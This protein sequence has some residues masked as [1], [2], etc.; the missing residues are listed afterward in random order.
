MIYCAHFMLQSTDAIFAAARGLVDSVSQRESDS[1]PFGASIL[2]VLQL[3]ASSA[4]HHDAQAVLLLDKN[5]NGQVSF[6]KV[7]ELLHWSSKRLL[8]NLCRPKKDDFACRLLSMVLAMLSDLFYLDLQDEVV[9]LTLRDWLLELHGR[10]K[11]HP[12]AF[13]RDTSLLMP[14]LLRIS[15]LL[16]LSKDQVDFHVGELSV[17][18]LS[19]LLLRM[20]CAT[21]DDKEETAVLNML[22]AAAVA[23]AAVQS[24][25]VRLAD[26]L[27]SYRETG[28]N[29]KGWA[30]PTNSP[31][32]SSGIF[33]H[34]ALIEASD[35]KERT[36]RV[37][38][39]LSGWQIGAAPYS[40]RKPLH[41]VSQ[42]VV[43]GMLQQ[44]EAVSPSFAKTHIGDIPVKLSGAR[45][46]NKIDNGDVSRGIN[47][48]LWQEII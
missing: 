9:C 27:E 37:H 28:E 4:L 33:L 8:P 42:M 43:A 36:A 29:D 11:E 10:G 24:C 35:D 44:L 5:V 48:N 3:W 2:R 6:P 16:S 20:D 47:A 26:E 25:L 1:D 22:G 21:S 12:A 32:S 41:K 30:A 40:V 17:S 38:R 34:V 31:R 14:S 39:V 19:V 13:S 45:A 46:E 7:T 15:S 23:E 18:L